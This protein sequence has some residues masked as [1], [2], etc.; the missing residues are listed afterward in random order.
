L[1]Q[2]LADIVASFSPEAIFLF[3]G[4]A[5]AGDFILQPTKKHM[6]ANM[7]PIFRGKVKLLISGLKEVNAA[8]MGSSALIWKELER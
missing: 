8:V 2:K 7:M 4:L 1:G 6:E 5:K 3:G